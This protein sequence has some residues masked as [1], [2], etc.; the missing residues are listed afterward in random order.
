MGRSAIAHIKLACDEKAVSSPTVVARWVT[1]VTSP[2]ACGDAL[3]WGIRADIAGSASPASCLLTER[4]YA[5]RALTTLTR[6]SAAASPG[7]RPALRPVFHVPPRQA[8]RTVRL[9]LPR[10]SSRPPRRVKAPG[11]LPGRAPSPASTA[12]GTQGS[13]ASHAGSEWQPR[14]V[15]AAVHASHASVGRAE[16]SPLMPHLPLREVQV[17]PRSVK[18][19]RMGRTTHTARRAKPRRRR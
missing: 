13:Y 14:G 5:E 11:S 19:P 18:K 3:P 10:P 9:S 2:H 1:P 4:P 7:A 16:L 15:L 6:R 17:G 12:G 8:P